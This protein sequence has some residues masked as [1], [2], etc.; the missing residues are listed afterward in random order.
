[1]TGIA[2]GAVLKLD[3]DVAAQEAID[4]NR[5]FAK[6]IGIKPAAR[7][8]CVKPSGTSSL[9]LGTSSGVHAWHDQYYIRRIR[10]GKNEAIYTYLAMYH[11]NMIEQDALNS[12]Q[13][14]LSVP[15][16]APEGAITRSSESALDF[17]ERVKFLH[18]AWIKPGTTLE[19]ILTTYLLR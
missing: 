4:A 1:M 19:T 14:V 13:V 9:V 10:I 8:T 7:L 12:N 5:M 11:P 15:V 17:L 3:L 16:A 18:G 6:L 2:S